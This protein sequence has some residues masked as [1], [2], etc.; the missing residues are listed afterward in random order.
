MCSTSLCCACVRQQALFKRCYP[1]TWPPPP[2]H[3]ISYSCVNSCLASATEGL[4]CQTLKST[5]INMRKKSPAL[6]SQSFQ[7]HLVAFH[8]G[9][10]FSPLMLFSSFSPTKNLY[11]IKRELDSFIIMVGSPNIKLLL[12]ILKIGYLYQ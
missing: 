4:G 3:L 11:G 2:C 9:N 7:L 1:F 8:S 10:K 6:C 5:C 12:S